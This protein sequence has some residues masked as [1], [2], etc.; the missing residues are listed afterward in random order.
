MTKLAA[1]YFIGVIMSGITSLTPRI[2]RDG[3]DP[4]E[5]PGWGL[6][7]RPAQPRRA[8]RVQHRVHSQALQDRLGD[9]VALH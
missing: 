5:G 3:G 1:A 8:D 2:S 6:R 9:R 7:R 4:G